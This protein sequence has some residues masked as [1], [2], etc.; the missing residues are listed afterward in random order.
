MKLV[1]KIWLVVAIVLFYTVLC[2]YIATQ[3]GATSLPLDFIFRDA[4]GKVSESPVAALNG[5]RITLILL[6]A[7]NSIAILHARESSGGFLRAYPLRLEENDS[8][9]N[10]FRRFIQ[11]IAIIAFSILPFLAII[12][13]YRN[14]YANGY[15]CLLNDSFNLCT[16]YSR[17]NFFRFGLWDDTFRLFGRPDKPG[18]TFALIEPLAAIILTFLNI[19]ASIIH[20]YEMRKAGKR[21]PV[22]LKTE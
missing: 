1:Q 19:I 9:D 12:H 6:L 8:F 5:L 14:L 18:A 15:I 2:G 21:T 20:F 10:G 4:E 11:F 17:L 13:F 7:T 16:Q 22:F 3:R